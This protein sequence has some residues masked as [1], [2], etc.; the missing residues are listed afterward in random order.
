MSQRGQRLLEAA[1]QPLPEGTFAV[2]AGLM[3]AGVTTYGFQ[4]LGFRAL[5]KPDYA[6]LNALWVFVFVL[7]PGIFLPLEQEVG[8]A[9]AARRAQGIGGGPIARRAGAL[10][11]AFA[12]GLAFLAVAVAAL[13][14]IVHDLFNGNAGL[15]ACL[16]ISLFTYGFELLAR[17]LFAGNGRFGAYGVSMGAEGTIRLLP[18]VVL[19]AA[20][21]PNPLW[22]GLC[23]AFPPLLATFVALRSQHDLMPAG[24]NAPWSE[25]S[26]NLGYL[27]FGSLFAQILSYAP[28][29][30]A[31]VLATSGQRSAVAD[32]IVGLFLSRIPILLFQAVQAALLPK[33]AALVSAGRHEDFRNGVRNLVLVV[34]G[35]G[36]IGVVAGGTAGPFVGKI[37]FGSKFHLNTLDL[38][39]LAAGSGLF[40]LALTL[41]Q[42]LIALLGHARAMVAWLL[43][44]VTFTV[45]TALAGSDLFLRVELGSIAGAGAAAGLMLVSL[46]QQLR[47][48]IAAGSLAALVEQIEHEPLEI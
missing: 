32:F 17:G 16:V 48:G 41:A 1:K 26:V 8:R 19:A 34:V 36:V 4:I 11:L 22:Y 43:G 30:G 5:S 24:P 44:I 12:V 45:V 18:V 21:V 28:F 7:A 9:I 14:P 39:L 6:A 37:L 20:G 15:I 46:V 13:T 38:A 23:L 40:I 29:L 31:Q 10:G 25:L 33:L 47:S 27:L 2:G 35:I 42:A 3:V